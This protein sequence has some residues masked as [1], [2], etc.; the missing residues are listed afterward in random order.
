M[1]GEYATE[2]ANIIDDLTNH[3]YRLRGWDEI[4]SE[5]GYDQK[6]AVSHEFLNTPGTVALGQPF[7]IQSHFA[8]ASGHLCRQANRARQSKVRVDDFPESNLYLND[9][10]PYG[11]GWRKFSAFKVQVEAIADSAFKAASDDFG[12]PIITA[13]RPDL[14]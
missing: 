11:A 12:T 6:I 3:V 8:F 13:S 5:L 2:L 14:Y 1:L 9:L 7:V 10:E 4:I